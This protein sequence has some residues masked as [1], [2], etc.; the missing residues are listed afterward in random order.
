[1]KKNSKREELDKKLQKATIQSF[2][3]ILE[4]ESG[5]GKEYWAKLI[6]SKR[7]ENKSF[8]MFDWECDSF[9]QMQILKILER[10]H[11]KQITDFKN[12]HKN[13][14]FFR[15]IDLVISQV[16]RK[17]VEAFDREV[18]GGVISRNQLSRLGLISSW[19]QKDKS[20]YHHS[21]ADNPLRELFPLIIKIPSLRERKKE[22]PSLLYD[23]LDWVNR[24]QSRKVFGFSKESMEIFLQYDWPN[25]L[26]ELQSEIERA[27]ALT[28][29]Y[30]IIKPEILSERL[31][32]SHLSYQT[33]LA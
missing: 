9:N 20:T 15:R 29:D 13:T 7:S 8:F 2:N 14:Y 10:D 33:A 12:P 18:E 21:Y 19:E 5:V 3:V 25:N 16:Q 32:G 11:L 1:M 6:H 4:G 24:E 30:E 26:D 17:L 27:V 23:I 22:L 31:M 28:E